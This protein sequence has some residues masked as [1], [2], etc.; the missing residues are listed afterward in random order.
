[1]PEDKLR[2][3]LHCMS[4]KQLMTIVLAQRFVLVTAGKLCFNQA[5]L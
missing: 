1:M 5:A 4:I 2:S 3:C